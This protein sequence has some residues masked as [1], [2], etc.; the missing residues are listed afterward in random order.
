MA[1]GDRPPTFT[2]AVVDREQ[3]MTTVWY[4]FISALAR[5]VFGAGQVAT[6]N[7]AV[8][9]DAAAITLNHISSNYHAAGV[10]YLQA[11]AATWVSGLTELKTDV[12]TLTTQL[13]DTRTQLNLAISL[14]NELKATV[15]QVLAALNE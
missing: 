9:A 15:D 2:A 1:E 6:I 13:Q 4:R 14:V 11:D 3:K 10:G 8:V 7:T 5:R 12:N